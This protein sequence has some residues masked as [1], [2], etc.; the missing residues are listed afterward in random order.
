MPPR[1]NGVIFVSP[2]T[3][4]RWIS[5]CVPNLVPI[6]PQAATCIRPEGY[7]HTHRQTH[8]HSPIIDEITHTKNKTS[9]AL[10]CTLLYN[11][12]IHEYNVKLC[13]GTQASMIIVTIIGNEITHT[14]KKTIIALHCTLLIIKILITFMVKSIHII[15][16]KLVTW[17][18]I[19]FEE[20]N[21]W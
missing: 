7:T 3:I 9:I 18:C 21:I 6:G 11:L 14:K 15:K 10:H 5:M 12:V 1:S 16:S 13:S 2:I 17:T 19:P 20:K 8:T 4:S